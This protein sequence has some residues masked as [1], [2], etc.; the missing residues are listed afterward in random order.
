MPVQRV[1][2]IDG[3]SLS[4]GAS[5]R[6]ASLPSTDVGPWT[7]VEVGAPYHKRG[8]CAVSLPELG[9]PMEFTTMQVWEFVPV[10]VVGAL[11]KQHGGLEKGHKPLF[12]EENNEAR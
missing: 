5:K 10:E 12:W 11:I 4:V 8:S 1:Y 3:H 6:H 2:M 9:E 7:H